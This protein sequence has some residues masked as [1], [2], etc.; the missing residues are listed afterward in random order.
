MSFHRG[1]RG[2]NETG[3]FLSKCGGAGGTRIT[4]QPDYKKMSLFFSSSRK[5]LTVDLAKG[6]SK[7]RTQRSF[8]SFFFCVLLVSRTIYSN[9]A[10]VPLPPLPL[11]SSKGDVRRA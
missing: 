1:S 11:L 7:V 2:K 4:S 5:F 8:I 10:G 3:L 9:L 6:T